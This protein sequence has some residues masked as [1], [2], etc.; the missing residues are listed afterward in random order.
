MGLTERHWFENEDVPENY[1]WALEDAVYNSRT[2][3]KLEDSTEEKLGVKRMADREKV[4]KE[5]SELHGSKETMEIIEQAIVLLK[6]QKSRVMTL[7]EVKVCKEP[8]YLEAI[9]F[10]TFGS[11]FNWGLVCTANENN[12]IVSVM[13]RNATMRHSDCAMYGK[14]WRCWTAKPTDKQRQEMKWNDESRSN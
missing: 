5:L 11:F 1:E 2:N 12:A 3:E 13:L 6:E 8:V 7:E 10:S 4:I 14:R 9:P